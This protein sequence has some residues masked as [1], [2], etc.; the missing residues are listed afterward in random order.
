VEIPQQFQ[1]LK[2]GG[3]ALSSNSTAAS[4]ILHSEFVLVF[5]CH[6]SIEYEVLSVEC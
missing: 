4:V 1:S 5:F 2:F 6:L 3:I